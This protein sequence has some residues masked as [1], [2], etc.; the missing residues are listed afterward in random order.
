[1]ADYAHEQTDLIIARTQRRIE[2]EYLKVVK[3][4]EAELD[5]YLRRFEKKDEKWREWVRDGKKTQEQYKNW[6][7]QQIAAGKVWQE[8]KEGLAVDYHNANLIAKRIVKNTMPEIY[9]LNHNYGTYLIERGLMMDT[10]YALYSRH[11]VDKILRDNPDLLPPPGKKVS[12]RIAEGLDIRWNKRKIQS[13][14]IQSILKGEAIHKIAKRLA[15]EVGDSNFKASIRNARTMA[16]GA[17][18][19]GRNDSFRRAQNMGISLRR[20]W[21]ATLDM[22][23]RHEHRLLDGMTVG[24]DEPFEVD[25]YKIR[26]PGDPNAPGHLV[27]NCRCTMIAQIMGFERDVVG[28]RADPALGDMTYEEWKRS[29]NAKSNPIT[30]PYEKGQAIR[31][32]YIQEYRTL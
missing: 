8:L 14:M 16:T 32:K 9:A 21:V 22:R 30:L 5:D 6:K 11:A 19:A 27:Y 1:M 13:V 7:R 20:T 23:T 2:R 15:R 18:N 31:H 3:E 4:V 29:K 28:L 25:G 26:F 12:E 17:Q 24:A 10:A